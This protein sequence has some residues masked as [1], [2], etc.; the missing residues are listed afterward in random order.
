MGQGFALG[1][2]NRSSF[3]KDFDFALGDFDFA[4]DSDFDPSS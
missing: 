1:G 3:L 4:L 2:G